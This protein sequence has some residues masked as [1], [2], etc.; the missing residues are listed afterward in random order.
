MNTDCMTTAS[1]SKSADPVTGPLQILLGTD[2][3]P[4][5]RD[6]A[7][8]L[9]ISQPT[10]ARRLAQA[11]RVWDHTRRREFWLITM[12]AL[13]TVSAVLSAVS[14]TILATSHL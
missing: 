6:I 10:A 1:D 4:S 11:R 7:R 9:H 13:L 8:F 14:L 2:S 5:T 3:E 12:Y